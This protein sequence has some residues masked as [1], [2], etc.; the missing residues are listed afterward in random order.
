MCLF[1]FH[2]LFPEAI[3]H[4]LKI[5]NKHRCKFTLR[6]RV[7]PTENK[8]LVPLNWIQRV[9][10]L[11][12]YF[13]GILTNLDLTHPLLDARWH[14]RRVKMIFPRLKLE[15]WQ[16]TGSPKFELVM[17]RSGAFERGKCGEVMVLGKICNAD[18]VGNVFIP[19]A[20]SNRIT[21]KMRIWQALK[22]KI[23]IY[24]VENACWKKSIL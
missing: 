7:L 14:K 4:F 17:S 19:T 5:I 10:K 24:A 22:H 15:Y 1:L 9:W 8:P 23:W 3:S 11:K 13:Q 6:C 18:N 21:L 12:L 20:T 2:I 16:I